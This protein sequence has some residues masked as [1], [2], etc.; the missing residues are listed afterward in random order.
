MWGGKITKDSKGENN[1]THKLLYHNL[2]KGERLK[3][4]HIMGCEN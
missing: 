4:I 3:D 2:E 1:A